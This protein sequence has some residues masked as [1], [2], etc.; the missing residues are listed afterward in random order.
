MFLAASLLVRGGRDGRARMD[1]TTVP[2]KEL[3]LDD[4]EKLLSPPSLA[5]V[6]QCA[7]AVTVYGFVPHADIDVRVAGATVVSETVGYPEPQGATLALPSPLVA[8]Q[9]VRVR[10]KSGGKT[11]PWSTPVEVKDHTEDF[12]TGP[13]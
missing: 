3:D 7:T 11:S 6:Y 12:P 2:L 5:A 4:N 10:Q 9:K 8:G 1:S 13:P